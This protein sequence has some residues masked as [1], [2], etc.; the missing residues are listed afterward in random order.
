M[1]VSRRSAR[2]RFI[3]IVLLLASVTLVT[4]D[5][6][7]GGAIPSLRGKARD[8]FSPV[9]NLFSDATSPITDFFQGVF[10]Y[11]QLRHDNAR[12]RT[13]IEALRAQQIQDQYLQQENKDL[14]DQLRLDFVGDIPTVASRVIGGAESN[15][16]VTVVIDRGSDAGIAKGMPVVAGSGLVGRVIEVSARQSTVILLT[17]ASMGVGVQFAPSQAVGVAQGQGPGRPLD[18]TLVDP[19]LDT[20]VGTAAVTSG[21]AGS[22]YPRGMPIGK[23]SRDVAQPGVHGHAV[24]VTPIVDLARLSYVDVLIWT[25]QTHPVATPDAGAPP[26]TTIAA[27]PGATTVPP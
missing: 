10:G 11:A 23:V 5:Q 21:L 15:F 14:T 20:P 12:L 4:L 3:L 8:A 1:A 24:S 25:P 7:G 6:R 2:P 18:V 26:P 13:Q 27:Q 17:D 19:S 22:P 9:Q 16:Q